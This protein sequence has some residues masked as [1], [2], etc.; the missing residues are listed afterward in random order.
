MYQI[1]HIKGVKI[2]CTTKPPKRVKEQ[3]FIEYEV[4]EIHEDV[5]IASDREI[6]LQKEYGY[7]VDTVPYWKSREIR[8]KNINLKAR[9]KGGQTQ[10][11]KMVESGMLDKARLK[12]NEVRRG[13]KHSEETKMKIKSMA[14]GNNNKPTVPISVFDKMNNLIG[15]YKSIIAAA[16]ELNLHQGNICKVLKGELLT[17]GGF[18][19][20]YKA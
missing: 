7:P 2:G 19:I 17:T 14:I 9:I 8:I 5:Y 4:L 18:I 10:G 6:E 15:E 13:S 16:N 3:G 1:Y 20:K 12:S 11:K